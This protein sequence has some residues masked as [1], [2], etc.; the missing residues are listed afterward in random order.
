VAARADGDAAGDESVTIQDPAAGKWKAVV[1]ASRAGESGAMYSYEDVILNPAFGHVAVTDQPQDRQPGASWSAR[2]NAWMAGDLPTGRVPY[3][4]VM[5]EAR[6]KGQ[7]PFRVTLR[8]LVGRI[9]RASGS[10]TR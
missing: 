3:A 1:D 6:P 9:D 8:E 2:A 5:L 7:A 10:G 4:A